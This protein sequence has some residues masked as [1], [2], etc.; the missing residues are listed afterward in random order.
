MING[1]ERITPDEAKYRQR[2]APKGLLNLLCFG[3]N[4]PELDKPQARIRL[5]VRSAKDANNR[6]GRLIDL[7]RAEPVAVATHRRPVVVAE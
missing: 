4:W 2:I 1:P 5:L 6:F 7:V 3:P